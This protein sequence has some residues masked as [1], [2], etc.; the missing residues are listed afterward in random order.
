MN[1]ARTGEAPPRVVV[2]GANRGVGL[3]ACRWLADRGAAVTLLV[4]S[5]TAGEDARE[6]LRGATRHRVVPCDLADPDS[7]RR[8]AAEILDGPPVSGLV[9]NAAVLPRERR[10]G[11]LGVELQMTVNHLSHFLLTRLLFPALEAVRAGRVVT[12]TS[13][14]H[15]GPPLHLDDPAYERRTYDRLVAYQQSKLANLAFSLALARR[16]RGSRVASVA[17]HPGVY[18]TG[19]LG[20]WTGLGSVVR[21]GAPG[22]EKGG[23]HVGRLA[24]AGDGSPADL[25][26]TY[27]E[28]N[29]RAR[30]A[31]AARDEAEQERLWRWSEI[32]LGLPPWRCRSG[33][34]QAPE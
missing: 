19:L 25:N 18:A 24:L 8:A 34:A 5:R 21:L 28:K 13:R 31:P 1:D 11:P 10:I 6:S 27:F 14:S 2:T 32:T 33:E 20:D 26:G 22:P 29:R 4:R 7:V 16:V 3:H 17:V 15:R 9:N 23:R 12:V 30:P